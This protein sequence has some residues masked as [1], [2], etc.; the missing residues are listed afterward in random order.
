MSQTTKWAMAM[1]LKRI[2]TQKPLSKITIADITEAC[3]INRMKFY[4]HFQD[5]FDLID[6]ICQ[7]EGAKAI[8]GRKNYKTWQEGFLALCCATKENRSFVEGVYHSIQREK[9][10]NYLCR[11]VYDL[12]FDVVCELSKDYYIS[13][14][15][16]QYIADFYKHGF[17]GIIL[18][19][20]KCGM[21]EDPKIF[22]SRVSQMIHGQLLLAIKNMAETPILSKELE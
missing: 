11:V 10:E 20:V 19:W 14:E 16:K 7:E 3:G 4:Y 17:V 22:V 13:L 1:A 8:Q 21:K 12:L 2:M 6:W 5:I 9:I 18:E 15:N